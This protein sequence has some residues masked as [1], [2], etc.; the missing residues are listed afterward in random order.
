MGHIAAIHSDLAIVTSDNP[1]AE[2]PGEII[3]EILPGIRR[4]CQKE[5][6]VKELN[7]GFTHKGYCLELDRKCAIQAGIRAAK[8]GDMVLIAGKGH[9]TYQIIGDIS[10][11]FD[12]RAV[13][14]SVLSASQTEVDK[15]R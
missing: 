5:Y 14:Q 2:K 6:T 15:Q 3:D 1:R 4:V 13:A 8:A 10:R 7:H 9:E 11:P 12:D